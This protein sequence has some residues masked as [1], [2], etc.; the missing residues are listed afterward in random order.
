MYP[1]ELLEHFEHPRNAGELPD[2]TAT[3][4]RENPVCGDV[5]QLAIRVEGGVIRAARFKAKGCV[6]AMACGSY[7][8]EW[9]QGK[10]RDEAQRFRRE[11]MVAALG[12]LSAETMHGGHLAAEA[13]SAVV[14]AVGAGTTK[15]A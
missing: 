6:T 11:E 12:G 2:A 1:P 4:V 14:D 7:V 3:V 5:L 15:R 10:S 9:L 8:A 13:V